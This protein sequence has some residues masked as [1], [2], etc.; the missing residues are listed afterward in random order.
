MPIARMMR[1]S[2]ASTAMRGGR[3]PKS[4]LRDGGH[5]AARLLPGLEAAVE[6][7]Y[8]RVAEALEGGAG[9]GRAAARGAVQEDAPGGVEL[10]LVVRGPRVG[11]ELEHAAG[12][13]EG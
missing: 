10:L 11:V 9:Q 7:C 2:R 1:T 3:P 6:V 13:G 12:G 4:L 5:F 8:A